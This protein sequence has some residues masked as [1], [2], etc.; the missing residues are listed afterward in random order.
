M[1]TAREDKLEA[2]LRSLF[3]KWSAEVLMNDA[4]K[5]ESAKLRA[6]V[7]TMFD[8]ACSAVAALE[9][10]KTELAH[11]ILSRAKIAANT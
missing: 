5:R 3:D 11:D 6:K 8:A 10:Q 1:P 9:S 4:L 2:E 7:K